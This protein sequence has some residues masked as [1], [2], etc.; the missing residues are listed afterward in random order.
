MPVDRRVVALVLTAALPVI[1]VFAFVDPVPQPPGYFRFADARTIAGIPNFWNVVS[2]LLFLVFGATGIVMLQRGRLAVLPGLRSACYALFAGITLTAFG[3][4]WFHLHP[5]ND[6]LFWDRLPMT[7][8]FMSLLAII[9]GEH[10]SVSV[11]RRSLV[12]LLLAGAASVFYW[13]ITEAAGHGDL[14]FYGIVQFLPMLLIPAVMILYPSAFDRHRFLWGVFGLYAL[15]KVFEALDAQVLLATGLVS[16][17]SLKHLAAS[18]VPLLLIRGMRN[19]KR[20]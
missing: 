2:N 11:G 12:P 16:G 13:D 19:R 20:R 9:L 10:V 3:S 18:F 6:S 15:S 7:V 14:R 1:A 4:G 17:H 8:A 5:G